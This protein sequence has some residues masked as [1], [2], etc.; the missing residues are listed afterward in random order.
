MDTPVIIMSAEP[1]TLKLR[2]FGE[3]TFVTV[4]TPDK[5]L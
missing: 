3:H 2:S 4:K 5:T 1:A